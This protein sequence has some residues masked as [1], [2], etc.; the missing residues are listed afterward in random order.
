MAANGGNDDLPYPR[1]QTVAH[2]ASP[3]KMK[4]SGPTGDFPQ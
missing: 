2:A 1:A 4:A 3:A